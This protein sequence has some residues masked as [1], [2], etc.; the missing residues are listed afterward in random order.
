[1]K[2]NY[3]LQLVG[4][5][6]ISTNGR[7]YHFLLKVNSVHAAVLIVKPYSAAVFVPPEASPQVI[8]Q[9]DEYCSLSLSLVVNFILLIMV[10][11]EDQL[12]SLKGSVVHPL[13]PC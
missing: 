12:G 2:S 4:L 6:F 8:A 13:Y 3:T 10:L 5:I 11:E 7:L 1:M 9:L